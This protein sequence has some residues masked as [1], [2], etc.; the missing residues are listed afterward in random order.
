MSRPIHVRLEALEAE[1]ATLTLSDLTDV[2]ITSAQD[3][4]VLKY[5]TGVW[6]NGTDETET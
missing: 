3:G 4:E 2:T 5:D 6:V 1:T